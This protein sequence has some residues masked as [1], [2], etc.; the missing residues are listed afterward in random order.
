M[1]NQSK[2][3]LREPGEQIQAHST[4][5]RPTAQQLTAFVAAD[6]QKKQKRE[7][8]EA[9]DPEMKLQLAALK[10]HDQLVFTTSVFYQLRAQLLNN[11]SR[12]S[13]QLTKTLSLKNE[14]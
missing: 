11:K 5:P 8:P 13:F 10:R 2:E 9:F 4:R 3:Q 6:H 1:E 14:M 12:Q 7:A